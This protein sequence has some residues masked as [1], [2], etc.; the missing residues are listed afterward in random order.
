MG[1]TW[2]KFSTLPAKRKKQNNTENLEPQAE[3]E[4]LLSTMGL[5]LGGKTLQ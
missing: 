3:S 4:L 1:R 5:A 2:A